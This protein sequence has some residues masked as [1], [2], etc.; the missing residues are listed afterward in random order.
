MI[1]YDT[2]HFLSKEKKG[3]GRPKIVDPTALLTAVETNPIISTRQLSADFGASHMTISRNLKAINKVY[4][5]CREVPHELTPENAQRRVEICKQLLSNPLDERFFKRIVTCDE[6]WIYFRN[7]DNRNQWL[8]PSQP[9]LPVVKRGRFDKKVM[10]CVWWNFQG[11]I[12][13]ELLPDG[14]SINAE[15]YSQQ[16][17]RMYASLQKKYPAVINRRRGLLIQDNAKPHVAIRTKE[18][19][20]DLDGIELLPHPAYSPDLAPLDYYLFRSMANF[21]KG[22]NF[23]NQQEVEIGCR[24]FFDSKNQ[25]WYK[26]GIE[27]LAER[28]L[29][30]VDHQGLYFDN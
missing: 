23:K 5:R 19:I 7:G 21:F 12:H 20:E 11:V 13:Y 14:F 8:D 29:K 28:W 4:R 26:R 2:K 16:L 9:A 18:K 24:D 22:R 30:T 10:L 15:L 25:A 1:H 3:S 27:L 6:K 17:D